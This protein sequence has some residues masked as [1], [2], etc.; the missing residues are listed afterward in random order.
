VVIPFRLASRNSEPDDTDAVPCRSDE[1]RWSENLRRN[2][3]DRSGR[4]GGQFSVFGVQ[5]SVNRGHNSQSYISV[6]W[7]YDAAGC[8]DDVLCLQTE[9]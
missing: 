6:S 3:R 8:S 5:F 2:D 7:L 9:N 1:R 4:P